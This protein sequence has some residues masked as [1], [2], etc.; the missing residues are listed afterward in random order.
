MLTLTHAAGD[1][2]KSMVANVRKG[3]D[4]VIATAPQLAKPARWQALVHYII[5]KILATKLKCHPPSEVLPMI[6][7]LI[8]TG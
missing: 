1:Q 2:I 4:A 6:S 7:P 5:A 8:A 3:L